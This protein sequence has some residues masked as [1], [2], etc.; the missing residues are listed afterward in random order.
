MQCQGH[1]TRGSETREAS[2]AGSHS[3]EGDFSE[4][5]TYVRYEERKLHIITVDGKESKEKLKTAM[6]QL[7]LATKR[8]PRHEAG[9]NK[10]DNKGKRV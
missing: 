6:E 1:E 7:L 8:G 4:K 9:S 2:L 10:I 3:H 5:A